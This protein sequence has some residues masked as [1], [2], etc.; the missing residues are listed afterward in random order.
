MG[1]A[2]ANCKVENLH[3]VKGKL[4]QAGYY[5]VLQ[6]HAILSGTRLVGQGFVFMQ[7]NDPKRTS[8]FYQRNIKSKKEQ[9]MLQLISWSVQ[10]ADLNPIERVLDELD[11][12]VRA[13]LKRKGL[14]VCFFRIRSGQS[15]MHQGLTSPDD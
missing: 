5:S 9:H 2:F 8:K 13:S 10:P 6:H 1:E 12:K 7:D 15:W 11:L 3:Q 14:G 4:N